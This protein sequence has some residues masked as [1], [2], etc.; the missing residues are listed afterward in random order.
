MHSHWVLIS[1]NVL[2][3]QYLLQTQIRLQTTYLKL[4]GINY[5]NVYSEL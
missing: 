4:L 3:V 2:P 1:L 5:P